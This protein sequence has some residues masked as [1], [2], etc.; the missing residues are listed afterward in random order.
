MKYYFLFIVCSFLIC[1]CKW[2]EHKGELIDASEMADIINDIA[3]AE[4]YI[5]SFLLKDSTQK[6]EAL[7]KNEIGK[8]L[9]VRKTDPEKFTRSY[10]YYLARPDE[11]KVIIDSANERAIREREK[12]Y[13]RT[14]TKTS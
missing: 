8:V 5:E 4:A 11:F 9:K 12:A 7:L 3:L 2:V 6:K 13:T 14:P 1:S 10:N